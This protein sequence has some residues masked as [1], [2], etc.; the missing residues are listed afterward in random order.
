MKLSR[1]GSCAYW[2]MVAPTSLAQSTVDV[3]LVNVRGNR[4]P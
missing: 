2:S 4:N 1:G 3:G